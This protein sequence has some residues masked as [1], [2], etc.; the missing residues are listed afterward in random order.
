[1]P[2]PAPATTSYS[3]LPVLRDPKYGFLNFVALGYALVANLLGLY[4]L[5]AWRQQQ[6]PTIAGLQL[7]FGL[8]AS[9]HGRVI[10]SYLVHE[11]AHGNIFR[12]PLEANAAFG[13]IALLLAGC[14]YADFCH[15]KH[16]HIAHHKDRGDAVEFDYRSFCR[17]PMVQPVVLALEFCYVPAVETVMH[18]RTAWAPLVW[19]SAFAKSRTWSSAI[20]I[21]I[22]LVWYIYLWK[23]GIFMLHIVAGAMVLQYLSLNDA[24]HHTYE[25]ILMKDYVPGPGPRTAQYEEENTY[26]YVR[27]V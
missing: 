9:A 7:L 10:A 6:N 16:M 8:L 15:V 17:L 20:G 1:M 13:R 24:F 27:F 3:H 12:K 2:P 11:A 25:A 21:P 4:S 22:Q 18:I 14:P 26:R 19:S 5:L 23:Q